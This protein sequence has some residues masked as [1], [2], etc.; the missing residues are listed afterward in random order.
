[1]DR[2]SV[3]NDFYDVMLDM[4][5]DYYLTEPDGNT[6]TGKISLVTG[7]ASS[8]MISERE[9]LLK[10]TATFPSVDAQTNFRGC[11]FRREMNPKRKYIL[12]S[13]IPRDTTEKV[14]DVYAV[15]CNTQVSLAI[16]KETTDEKFDMVTV[17][18][19]YAKDIDVYWDSTMQKQRRSS[20]GNFD[21][22]IYAMQIPAVYSLAVDEVVIRKMFQYNEETGKNELID[23]IFRVESIDTAMTTVDE[24]G[25]I[26]GILDVQMSLDTR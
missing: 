14:A 7:T 10:G 2:F 20:D 24:N 3:G 16:L 19:I 9:H 4:A 12:I 5:E 25:Y 8:Y 18:E 22:T 21:Q 13:T 11:Y 15:M 1:M 6:F 26:H 17:P 23:T